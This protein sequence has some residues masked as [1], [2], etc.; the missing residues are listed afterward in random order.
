[1]T[2]TPRR[3]TTVSSARA[4]QSDSPRQQNLGCAELATRSGATKWSGPGSNRRPPACKADPGRPRASAGA[5]LPSV[6]PLPRRMAS[7]RVSGIC[8]RDRYNARLA[9]PRCLGVARSGEPGLNVSLEPAIPARTRTG[10]TTLRRSYPAIWRPACAGSLCQCTWNHPAAPSP[11]RTPRRPVPRL[12]C[13]HRAPRRLDGGRIV[14]IM[15]VRARQHPIPSQH[16]EDARFACDGEP[17]G[18]GG[19]PRVL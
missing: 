8:Y 7:A 10:V 12:S 15:E 17:A 19:E 2:A 3:S 4:N 9:I 11:N 14:S 13:G 16:C 1:V 18:A 6:A 5:D